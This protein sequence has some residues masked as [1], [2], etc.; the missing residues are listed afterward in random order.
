MSFC[1][2]LADSDCGLRER[3]FSRATNQIIGG[4][5][6]TTEQSPW[7]AALFFQ[8]RFICTANIIDTCWVATAAHCLQGR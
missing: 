8:G 2:T 7:S 6:A 5:E 4:V 3:T 1:F